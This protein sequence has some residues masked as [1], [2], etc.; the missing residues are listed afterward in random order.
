MPQHGVSHRKPSAPIRQIA[1]LS[2]LAPLLL[3]GQ[4]LAPLRAVFPGYPQYMKESAI[5][6]VIEVKLEVSRDGL[7]TAAVPVNVAKDSN[8]AVYFMATLLDAVWQWRYRPAGRG[9][10]VM[11]RFEYRLEVSET[12]PDDYVVF[13]PPAN[14]QIVGV[15]RP[16]APKGRE[17]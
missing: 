2:M 13:T 1:I 6:H 5:E 10:Q 11:L 16:P 14:V 15:K 9:S 7:V 3:S 12:V 17:K 4:N 8:P